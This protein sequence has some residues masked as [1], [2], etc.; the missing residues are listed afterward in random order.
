MNFLVDAQLPTRLARF[1]HSAGHDARHTTQLP[2]GNRTTDDHVAKVADDEDRIV[3]SKDA[4]FRISHQLHGRPRRLLVVAMGNISN[5][6]L[7]TVFETHL[8][9]IVTAFGSADR[10]EVR[11]TQIVA[12]ARRTPDQ[13][14]T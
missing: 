9:A 5:N 6:D 13:A 7:L 2:E 8:D 11:P 12:W 1:L 14:Q 10:V 4:D 3:V